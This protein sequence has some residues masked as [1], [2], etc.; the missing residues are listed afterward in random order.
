MTFHFNAKNITLFQI[1]DAKDSWQA[2][3]SVAL[4]VFCFYRVENI[5]RRWHVMKARLENCSAQILIVQTMP[6][7]GGKKMKLEMPLQPTTVSL[8]E[9]APNGSPVRTT[10]KVITVTKRTTRT[11][12]GAP[13]ESTTVTRILSDGTLSEGTLTVPR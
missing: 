12:G 4:T 6:T 7:T 11:A 5:N 8:D 9:S 1:H 2:L 13:T 3:F 10:R